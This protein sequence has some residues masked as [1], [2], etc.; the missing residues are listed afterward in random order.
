MI[1]LNQLDIE[2]RQREDLGDIP[3]QAQSFKEFGQLQPIVVERRGDRFIL[4]AG[5]R[6]V[7]AATLLGWTEIDAV[8]REE[9]SLLQ[10]QLLEL[11]E[12]IR[13]K[14]L[15]W[16]ETAKAVQSIHALKMETEKGW[17]ADKTAALIGRSRR[18]T[19][20]FIELAG[21]IDK[22]PDVGNADKPNAAM[23]RLRQHKQL[24]QRKEAV[25]LQRVRVA[26][27]EEPSLLAWHVHQGDCVEYMKTLADG[28][29]D[30]ILTD[31][32][33]AVDY[34]QLLQG[35]KKAFDD[36]KAVLPFVRDAMRAC[37]R[38][39]RDER[40]CLMYWPTNATDLPVELLKE[41]GAPAGLD[42]HRLGRWFLTSAGFRVW[43]RP[44]I[45]YK[46]NKN[47]GS[48][49]DPTKELTSQYETVFWAFKGDARFFKRPGSDV[50][51][52]EAPGRDRIH[53][54]EKSVELSE[55]FIDICTV[56]G[57]N[58]FDP[59]AGGGA[60]GEAGLRM[61]RNVHLV[62]L[63]PEFASRASVR[64]ES[65]SQRKVSGELP[66][67][68]NI[69]SEVDQRRSG[70]TDEEL[71]GGI[72]LPSPVRAKIAQTVSAE[73]DQDLFEENGQ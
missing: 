1:Q 48:I 37:Y 17:N 2:P 34:D 6:R 29:M 4:R 5:G 31:P 14:D 25:E 3:E 10:A 40:F 24:I 35:N 28:T 44:V 72:V 19:Y 52:A 38:L 54:N 68:G 46:P 60:H 64:C 33:W 51:V 73:L 65:T 43:P 50:F 42:L 70:P 18:H 12:N 26:H 11:E 56:Q 30:M 61:E 57:E 39:L 21:A 15:E 27:G 58:V 22:I 47:F 69:Q 41:L 36:S 7:A 53:P 49:Q 32:P 55:V 13:R 71:E 67:L 9:M 23:N 20:N 66:G 8:V 45:W 59:F 16:Q 62:E 63:D